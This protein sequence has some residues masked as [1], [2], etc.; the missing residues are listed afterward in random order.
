[1]SF[2]NELENKVQ[3]STSTFPNFKQISSATN[4]R[5]IYKYQ[6]DGVDIYYWRGDVDEAE[7]AAN[8]VIF[9]GFCWEMVRTTKTGGIKI[10]YDGVP[11]EVDGQQTC[12]NTGAASQ[13]TST[14]AFNG[15]YKSPAYVGYMY[16]NT[17]YEYQTKTSSDAALTTVGILYGYDVEW[18]VTEYKLKAKEGGS[19]FTSTGVWSTDRTSVGNGN[20]YTC[21]D[22]DGSCE[23]VS[24]VYYSGSS[25]YP[26][27]I[28][29][30][31]GVTIEEALEQMY[32]NERPS[33]IKTNIETWFEGTELDEE[34]NLSKLED[35]VFCNDRS[36]VDANNGWSKD[37]DASKNMY[38]SSYTRRSNGTPDLSCRQ[39]E[40]NRDRFTY[41]DTT[42]GNGLLKWPVGLLTADEI[43]L[44]GGQNS[45]NSDYYLY[46]GE[47]Y[48]ALSP[49]G[50]HHGY[51][52]GFRVS[53]NGTLGYGYVSSAFGVRPV[54]SLV[55]GTEMSGSGTETSPYVVQ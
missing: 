49:Y 50:F 24:Y 38:Y 37:G 1:M 13:L 32:S 30:T 31:G 27:Y 16:G 45:S 10:I 43:M 53:S 36:V 46:T 29:L 15:S 28:E 21:F 11:V 34:E 54:V 25:S 41:E 19:L 35:V 20:H 8:H 6:E 47:Y 40:G 39:T 23:T 7:G 55:A 2:T 48:W 5:G 22:T 9:A 26:Y 4:G 12:P 44:A 14:S 33:T 52:C 17:V 42:N 18:T 51:A 3:E